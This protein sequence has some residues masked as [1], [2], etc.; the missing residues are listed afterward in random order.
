M[1]KKRTPLLFFSSAAKACRNAARGALFRR[2]H[3]CSALGHGALAVVLAALSPLAGAHPLFPVAAVLQQRMAAA[4]AYVAGAAWLADYRQDM[5]AARAGSGYALAQPL[6]N[7]KAR[8]DA[9]APVASA[10]P[11]RGRWIAAREE[12]EVVGLAAPSLELRQDISRGHIDP[13]PIEPL[14]VAGAVR[15]TWLPRTA[16]RRTLDRAAAAIA[17]HAP[18]DR[19]WH[20]LQGGLRQARKTSYLRDGRLLRAYGFLEAAQAEAPLD[21]RAAG[22]L[23]LRASATLGTASGRLAVRL[24]DMARRHPQA[25]AIGALALHLKDDIAQRTRF[26]FAHAH[27]PADYLSSLPLKGI[28]PSAS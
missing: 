17:E 21:D 10:L 18:G 11:G 26:W 20:I 9:M 22:A 12:D 23:L 27:P 3:T 4:P 28:S 6:A 13:R 14:L 24:R 7:L 15:V 1:R 25:Y 2:A 16:L 19:V 5:R 8:L